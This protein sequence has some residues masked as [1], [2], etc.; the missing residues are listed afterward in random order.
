MDEQ[1]AQAV[2]EEGESIIDDLGGVP[3]AYALACEL[4]GVH[5][6]PLSEL[7]TIWHDRFTE[8]GRDWVVILNGYDHARHIEAVDVSIQG[9]AAL[10][11]CD[12]TL[13]VM[14]TPIG[15]LPF[16]NPSTGGPLDDDEALADWR[17]E[18]LWALHARLTGKGK[19]LPPLHVMM[20]NDA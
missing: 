1:E 15:V 10:V 8:E 20:R 6:K 16:G 9:G 4:P 19:D 5:G 13:L 3:V 12:E 11:I 14:L 7:E 18:L 2:L 17:W